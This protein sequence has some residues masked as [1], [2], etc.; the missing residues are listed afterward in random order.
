MSNEK[1]SFQNTILFFCPQGLPEVYSQ[2]LES[3]KKTNKYDFGEIIA[4]GQAEDLLVKHDSA[5]VLFCI[6]TKDDLVQ[7]LTL[8]KV[9]VEKIRQG[10]VKVG[11]LNLTGS[12]K[13]DDI[14]KKSGV[15]DVFLDSI[16][17]KTLDYK[18]N[19]WSKG[20][21]TNLKKLQTVIKGNFKF[22]G[23]TGGAQAGKEGAGEQVDSGKVN[24]V[25]ALNFTSDCW[26]TENAPEQPRK[27][28]GFW[29][30]DLVGPSPY[31]GRWVE[32][33][34]AN[35]TEDQLWEWV[36]LHVEVFQFI[37]HEGRWI[38]KG[39]QP[40]FL[41]KTNSWKFMGAAPALCFQLEKGDPVVRFATENNQLSITEDSKYAQAKRVLIQE[42]FDPKIVQKKDTDKSKE[43][44]EEDAEAEANKKA[45]AT[46]DS[47]SED[48]EM[49]AKKEAKQIGDLKGVLGAAES[50]DDLQGKGQ[51][52]N[53]SSKFYKGKVSTNNH[54]DDL[55]EDSIEQE[56]KKRSDAL[57]GKIK[58][59]DSDKKAGA[60]GL[61]DSDLKMATNSVDEMAKEIKRKREEEAKKKDSSGIAAPKAI[62]GL[63]AG[64]FKHLRDGKNAGPKDKNDVSLEE[65]E[66][67]A[68]HEALRSDKE[69]K[70]PDFSN[71]KLD[72]AFDKEKLIKKKKDG[73]SDEDR[74]GKTKAESLIDSLGDEHA[75]ELD[76]QGDS[77]E[78]REREGAS[79][80][81]KRESPF[82]KN[83]GIPLVSGVKGEGLKGL[84]R[85]A[86]ERE[87]RKHSGIGEGPEK[88]IGNKLGADRMRHDP[89]AGKGGTDRLEE[90][91]L[92]GEQ[93]GADKLNKFLHGKTSWKDELGGHL[94]LT[95]LNIELIMSIKGS[96]AEQTV[97]LGDVIDNLLV[98]YTPKA[99]YSYE[100]S[101]R[102]KITCTYGNLDLNFSVAGK[103]VD[104]YDNDDETDCCNLELIEYDD[105]KLKQLK[106]LFG[107]RQKDITNFFIQAKGIT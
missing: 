53:K 100:Q 4:S 65:L 72:L 89:M 96:A 16:S 66:K 18:L 97:T 78:R 19:F 90:D 57:S 26:L 80:R 8:C 60:K 47:D 6:Q 91:P 1:D 25:P 20:I 51:E 41:W 70:K 85:E 35:T 24:V 29:I 55:D 81:E 74:A 46:E 12:H 59:D 22:D 11:G 21:K 67:T 107:D 33:K 45:F 56:V 77:K 104:L 76:L 7:L 3:D 98:L 43:N 28:M 93:D 30:V 71:S 48:L 39:K 44:L 64:K 34:N 79:E 5:S 52:A 63:I 83:S 14:L 37:E 58:K 87:G 82:R 38:A 106:R 10:V 103:I 17:S 61:R 31:A 105:S 73:E 50:F 32:I 92:S 95:K 13:L 75:D 68:K 86:E 94:R 62:D 99:L 2:I 88:A 84:K 40:Q 102:V 15:S 54:E 36:P 9:N 42:S 49:L 23:K 69:F 27:V 101:A